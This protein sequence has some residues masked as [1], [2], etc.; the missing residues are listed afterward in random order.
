MS[1]SFFAPDSKVPASPSD[2]ARASFLSNGNGHAEPADEA[3]EQSGKSTIVA[4]APILSYCLA[5]I[6]MTVLNKVG[7]R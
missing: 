3:R 5:S 7:M 2:S 1:R 4:L 6:T